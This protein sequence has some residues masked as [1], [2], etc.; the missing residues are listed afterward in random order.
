MS[1]QAIKRF[2]LS[3]RR[4]ATRIQPMDTH[5]EV[6]E[7]QTTDDIEEA[8]KTGKRFDSERL[9]KSALK[10]TYI[11]Y[12][13]DSDPEPE[14][15]VHL[16]P[17]KPK[18]NYSMRIVEITDEMIRKREQE[19]AYREEE[20]YLKSFQE[21]VPPPRAK[22]PFDFQLD[23]MTSALEKAKKELD[24]ELIKPIPNVKGYIPPTR[25][26]EYN[27]EFN[28]NV[29]RLTTQIQTLENGIVQVTYRVNKENERWIEYR[30]IMYRSEYIKKKLQELSAMRQENLD[31]SDM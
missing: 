18:S 30:K 27:L 7:P 9:L 10:S 25:K 13:E 6:F 17:V 4:T 19:E 12:L 5:D 16:S 1:Q 3:Q 24:E 26:K 11:Q 14:P 31:S 20:E 8:L 22:G 2:F 21:Y 23:E 28:S 29:K 15:I